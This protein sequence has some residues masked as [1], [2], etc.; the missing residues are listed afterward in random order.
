MTAAATGEV[1]RVIVHWLVH[2]QNC[3]NVLHFIADGTPEIETGLIANVRGAFVTGLANAHFSTDVVLKDVTAYRIYPTISRQYIISYTDA[4]SVNVDAVPS[5]VAVIAQV[6]TSEGGRS[7][8]GR[9]YVPGIAS[10]Q[11]SDSRF[12]A[13]TFTFLANLVASFITPS[14]APRWR[15]G[16]L[17]RKLGGSTI[18]ID[19]AGFKVATSLTF[20]PV[21]G[22]IRTRRIGRGG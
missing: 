20:D 7:A 17:S 10:N 15:L 6:R 2:A 5:T 11:V 18:P 4:G 19:I 8:R 12:T 3:Y 21:L 16:L 14:S 9:F 22:T 13:G 1:Y